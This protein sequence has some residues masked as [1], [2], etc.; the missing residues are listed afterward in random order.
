MIIDACLE[1]VTGSNVPSAVRTER[2]SAPAR[3]CLPHTRSQSCPRRHHEHQGFA[4]FRRAR[5]P[6]GT[7]RP[8]GTQRRPLGL[9][10]PGAH[11]P[12]H[13]LRAEQPTGV[14][15]AVLR[16]GAALTLWG[17]KRLVGGLSAV[18]LRPL[19]FPRECRYEWPSTT[20]DPRGA[21]AR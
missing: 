8:L 17:R 5:S 3:E 14:R 7:R 4:G 16:S 9:S 6:L 1:R 12:D 21:N 20:S 18:S 2:R 13:D 11:G 10:T 19:F 15:S